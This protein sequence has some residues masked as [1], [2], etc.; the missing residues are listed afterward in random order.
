[1][2]INTP[3]ADLSE[4][5][6]SPSYY[7]NYVKHCYGVSP[8]LYAYTDNER[9]HLHQINGGA[10][11]VEING[12]SA[13]AMFEGTGPDEDNGWTEF[14]IVLQQQVQPGQPYLDLQI[15]NSCDSASPALQPFGVT[16]SFDA[17]KF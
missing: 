5:V 13:T 1:M 4:V 15:I 12:N 8:L 2:E 3:S 14:Q 16:C 11:E 6:N 17:C 10:E 9:C 7:I